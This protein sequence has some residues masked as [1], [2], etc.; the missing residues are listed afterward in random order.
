[1]DWHLRASVAALPT[2]EHHSGYPSNADRG[3]IFPPLLCPFTTFIIWEASNVC[4][5]QCCVYP[6]LHKERS[7]FH[8]SNCGD[9][10]WSDC[11]NSQQ[12]LLLYPVWF[13]ATS[14]GGPTVSQK[15]KSNLNLSKV[16]SKFKGT[17]SDYLP[18]FQFDLQI[19]YWL[20]TAPLPSWRQIWVVHIWADA[21]LPVS[22]NLLAWTGT[23]TGCN[24]TDSW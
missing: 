3:R 1:M 17:C 13:S 4:I 18:K 5:L 8:G 22:W 16:K 19:F 20:K 7:R 23:L 15:D 2:V 11:P 21:V 6:T 14:A 12:Q 10:K 24:C 9:G